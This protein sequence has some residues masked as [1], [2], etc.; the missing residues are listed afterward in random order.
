LLPGSC[1]ARKQN[2]SRLAGR[3][4]TATTAAGGRALYSAAENAALRAARYLP[5]VC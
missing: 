1:C 5:R 4:T 2:G 3:F